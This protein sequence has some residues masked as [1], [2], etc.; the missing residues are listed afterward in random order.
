[1]NVPRATVA[2]PQETPAPE[3]TPTPEEPSPQTVVEPSSD[4]DEA[5]ASQLE[6]TV[7]QAAA[8]SWLGW[9]YGQPAQTA[10]TTSAPEDVKGVEEVPIAAAE[11]HPPTSQEVTAPPQETTGKTVDATEESAKYAETAAAVAAAHSRSWFGLW[12][13]T[14]VPAAPT[15]EVQNSE[16]ILE[17]TPDPIS[18]PTPEDPFRRGDPNLGV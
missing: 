1:M 18:K 2:P 6:L 17:P 8:G 10:P 5:P 12:G 11:V 14:Q 9:W 3:P 4:V 7:E 16:P 13:S 15:E